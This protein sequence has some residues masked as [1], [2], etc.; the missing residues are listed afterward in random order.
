MIC[1]HCNCDM[2]VCLSY[3]KDQKN[4]CPDCICSREQI[5]VFESHFKFCETFDFDRDSSKIDFEEHYNS[6]LKRS[7][8]QDIINSILAFLRSDQCTK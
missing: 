4:C 7:N 5:E 3:W 1:K 6:I 2:K 8:G